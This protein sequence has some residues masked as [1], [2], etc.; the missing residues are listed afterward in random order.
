MPS[1]CLGAGQGREEQNVSVV[2][3]VKKH[4]VF[5]GRKPGSLVSGL[6]PPETSHVTLV[7]HYSSLCLSLPFSLGRGPSFPGIPIYFEPWPRNKRLKQ[8]LKGGPRAARSSPGVVPLVALSVGSPS[9]DR[10]GILFPSKVSI[11][12]SPL[13]GR[14]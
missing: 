9:T 2:C 11:R 12:V 4:G 8:E 5:P 14:G 13:G 1:P 6:C 10:P 7:N 3:R